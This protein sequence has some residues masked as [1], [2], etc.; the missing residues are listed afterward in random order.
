MRSIA[1]AS[2]LVLTL[3][4]FN[5]GISPTPVAAENWPHWRGPNFDGTTDEKGLPTTW[6][7]TEDGSENI[8]WQVDLP[9][10]AGSTPAV[11]QDRIF[12]TSGDKAGDGLW[13]MAFDR[14][15]KELWRSAVSSGSLKIM[16]Q[17]AH[18]TNAAA[19]SPVT[20]GKRLYTLFGTGELSAFDFDGKRLWRA[21]LTERYG[22]PNMYFGLSTSPLVIGDR[23]YMHLLHTDA[24]LVLALDTKTGAELWKHERATD[25]TGE[26]LHSYA[27]VMP[28]K[29][30]TG[31]ESLLV[32]GSDYITAHALKDGA[33]LWR[34][35]TVNPKDNYNSFFRLVA[36]P[37]AVDGLIVVPTA[38][39]GPVFGLRPDDAKGDKKTN[40]TLLSWKLDKGTP[41]VPS[42]VV[43]GGLVY[44]AGENGRL[45]VLDAKT[46]ETVYAE[47]VHQSQHRGSP[48]LADG[49][50]FL[51]ATDGTVSVVRPGRTFEVLSKNQVGGGRLA[52]SPAISDGTIYLRTF[53]KLYAVGKSDAKKA[54][55]KPLKDP[56]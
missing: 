51:T 12:V 53:E 56:S 27:S 34:Y 15:G 50:L 35:G 30:K 55:E 10:P 11:W 3:V 29:S 38:K 18:E 2:L 32:H 19:S 22:K 17:F 33:E 49:K 8:R 20:D 45:T 14:S 52:A 41:D 24:Q 21:D 9:G 1:T 6:S 26:C 5:A 48:I 43:S 54:D 47:R 16:E 42:P 13:V 4:F 36:S 37:V 44:L 7:A 25:A 28:F 23:L 31:G 40:E 39:R 46:G